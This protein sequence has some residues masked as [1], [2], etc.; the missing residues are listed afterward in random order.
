MSSAMAETLPLILLPPS[1]GKADGGDGSPWS[2]GSMAIDLDARRERVLTALATS[3]R[4]SEAERSRLLG[5]KGRALADAT[6]A[7][8]PVATS[9]TMLAIERYTG[10]LYDALEHRSLSTAHRRRLDASVVIVSG[11]WGWWRRPTRSPTTS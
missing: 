9:P 2:H 11:L 8:R 10:V 7:N 1:E 3:M 6:A 4:R 5:V